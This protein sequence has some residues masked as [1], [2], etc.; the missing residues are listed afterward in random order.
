ML[1][2]NRRIAL[3]HL[4]LATM[5]AT[6]IAAFFLLAWPR[7]LPVQAGFG[8]VAGGLLGWML[9]LE[10]LS[11]VSD[12]PTYDAIALGGLVLVSLLLVWLVLG[13]GGASNGLGWFGAAPSEEGGGPGLPM[14]P[15]LVG[16]NVLLWQRASAATSRELNFF[17][18][19]MTFRTGLLLLIFGGS[20]LGV[21]RGVNASGL[22]WL[23]LAV[24]LAA[25]AISRVSEKASEAQSAG[26]LLPGPR[27][28]Q[29]GLAAAAATGLTW[30][31]SLVY[32]SNG[33]GAFVR[34]FDPL[35]QLLKPAALAMVVLLGKLLNPLLLWLEAFLTGLLARGS[36]NE[37]QVQPGA[38]AGP[39]N[40]PLA[41]LPRWPFDLARTA[42]L[43]VVLIMAVLGVIVFLL[44]YL[45]RVRRSGMRIEDE[46]E[47]LERAT[48]GGGILRRAGD[49]LRGVGALV[50]RFGIGWEL[51]AAISVENI[52]ANLCRIARQR[53]H[54]R[55]ASQPPDAYLPVLAEVFPGQDERLQRITTAYMRVHYGEHPAPSAELAVLREDY[56][57]LRTGATQASH[58]QKGVAKGDEP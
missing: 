7:A 57:A 52:Y 5:Q 1:L 41:N 46:D 56:A 47:G 58:E 21:V 29:V 32:T 35:W 37:Q 30:L 54:P 34:L 15:V 31:F 22:L 19:G 12:S 16:L 48:M 38:A 27:L 40:N 9:T 24:G 25:V 23:Y 42:I 55:R 3:L 50:R 43:V 17:S 8:I 13:R 6:W 20:L 33:I 44:L 51:L 28:A 4:L 11:R 2:S 45:E 49:A 39:G 14:L 26:R 53:G 36:V 10:L 18:V